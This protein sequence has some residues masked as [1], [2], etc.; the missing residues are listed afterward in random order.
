LF[1]DSGTT[2]DY[3]IDSGSWHSAGFDLE[4]HVFTGADGEYYKVRNR[5]EDNTWSFPNSNCKTIESYQP[6]EQTGMCQYGDQNH[7]SNCAK[8]LILDFSQEE[9]VPSITG[10]W[11]VESAGD[12]WTGDNAFFYSYSMYCR[13]ISNAPFD[14]GTFCKDKP[15][16]EATD[17]ESGYTVECNGDDFNGG[18][19]KIYDYQDPNVISGDAA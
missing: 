5:G 19:T 18:W 1:V 9:T 7:P 10:M 15:T 3:A 17:E 13:K 14:A 4:K 6:F 12:Q 11:D 8:S 2:L 16:G